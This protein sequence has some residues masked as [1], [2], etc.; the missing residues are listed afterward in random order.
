VEVAPSRSKE[1][2][3]VESQLL[4]V[5]TD[6]S[7]ML[8]EFWSY[9]GEEENY[10]DVIHA[11]TDSQGKFQARVLPGS[12][13]SVFVNDQDQVSNNW[14][15]VI[16]PVDNTILQKPVLT[17]SPGVLVEILATKG[18]NH[19]PL[20]NAWVDFES[21][22]KSRRGR[23][24]WR[25]TDEQGKCTA[26]VTAGELELRVIDGDWESKKTEKIVDGQ[27][28][29]IRVHRQYTEKKT[30]IGKLVLP[31]GVT[32][33]L[34]Q[35]T[36]KIA[37]MDG[38]S[39]DVT[40]VTAD[41]QGNFTAG[42]IAGRISILAMSPEEK[43]FGGT[44][45]NVSKELI[46]VPFHPT[47]GYGAQVLGDGDRP[48]PG[49][50]VRL[51]ARLTDN[52]REYPPG[53]A[54]FQRQ[55]AQLYNDRTV[56]TDRNGYFLF[57]TT[58]QRMELSLHF[59]RPSETESA[60]WRQK[61]LE[62]GEN[63]PRETV[64]IRD[65]KPVVKTTKPLKLTLAGRV[66]NCRLA[67]IHALIVVSGAGAAPTSFVTNRVLNDEV[68]RDI[69]SYSPTTINGAEAAQSPDQRE[70][71]TAQKWPFP[72]DDS[73]FLVALNGDGQ[74]L[75]R[76]TLAVRDDQAAVKEVAAFLK[77]HLPPRRDAK[78][79]Y[80]AA[81]AEAKQTGRR[82]WVRVGGTRCRPCFTLSSWLDSQR[83]LLSQD[84]VLFK[85]DEVLDRHGHELSV[86]LKFEAFGIPCHAILDADGKELINSI[87]PLGNIG[88]PTGDFEGTAHLKK[89]LQTTAR[90]LT[91]DD[92]ES[93]IRSLSDD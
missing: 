55:Y 14:G 45:V 31:A 43:Y 24:F 33:D 92:I 82:L 73:L 18:H 90:K 16:A 47:V 83:E 5:A 15:G 74:E 70:Y 62:P 63:R 40:T 64:H 51:T 76:L 78:L 13:Y 34:S 59:T 32:A 56:T 57:P 75:G 61:W 81:L 35:T 46:E 17:L 54:A 20:R 1:R 68:S 11:R 36:V 7:G 93:L 12:N 80:E 27:P 53:T 38:E 39:K 71:F 60:A 72:D 19:E 91:E 86:A 21:P 30:I 3:L 28:V 52:Q 44:I 87:G 77:T 88:D 85:F 66:R 49:I 37:G 84:Y 8:V 10:S 26:L 48:L 22:Q 9:Q 41:A 42:I 79:G 67:G 65:Q 6:I 2:V 25:K 23:G 89:M 29:Q 69:F 58:P 50:N 4:G